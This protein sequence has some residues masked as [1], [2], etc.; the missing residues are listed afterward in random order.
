MTRTPSKLAIALSGSAGTGKT[1]LGRRLAD[2]LGI[3]YI[4]EGMRRRLESGLKLHDLDRVELLA[5]IEEIWREQLE[6]E[7]EAGGAFVVD[8]SSY[9]F[10]AFWLHYGMYG[11]DGEG[12]QLLDEWCDHGRRYDRV[13]LLPWGVLP[14]EADGIRSVNPW[15]QLRFQSIL[16]GLLQRRAPEGQILRMPADRDLEA[17]VRRVVGSLA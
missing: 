10:A 15:I 11:R 8:R 5:L 14:A 17:R 9:D 6:Q 16:E 1:T 2:E 7:L 3:V 13:V 4:E 12:A